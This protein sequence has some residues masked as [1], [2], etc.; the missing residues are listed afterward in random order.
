MSKTVEAHIL[1]DYILV[2]EMGS[3]AYGHVWE[4]KDKDT[5][6][7]FALKKVFDAFRNSID[8]QRTYREVEVLHRLRHENIVKLYRVM[9][10]KNKKDLYLVFELMEA[11]LHSVVGT[12]ILEKMHQIYIFYQVLR[13]IHY[14]HSA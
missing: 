8:A 3:G 11:D 10:S 14:I 7:S 4:V 6:Q 9:K 12:N 13:A 5:G 1:R 2:R